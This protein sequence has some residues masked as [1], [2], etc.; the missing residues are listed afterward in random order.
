MCEV[1]K[2]NISLYKCP[3]CSVFSCSLACCKEHK[4]VQNCSGRRDK[5]AFV[6]IAQFREKHLRSDFHF[7]EDILQ[8]K[9]RAKRALQHAGG[10]AGGGASQSRK[11]LRDMEG[12]RAEEASNVA[13]LALTPADASSG[14]G[15]GPVSARRSTQAL[16]G[17]SAAV[18]RLVQAAKGRG[19]NLII[20]PPGMSKRVRNTTTFVTDD[21]TVTWRL[22]MVFV[23]SAAVFL[24]V[25]LLRAELE[26]VTQGQIA[27]LQSSSS[28]S[29][30][31]SG[32]GLVGTI[33]PKVSEN[34]TVSDILSYFLDPHGDVGGDVSSRAAQRYALRYLRLVPRSEL[35]M[36]I[37]SI[38]SPAQDPVFLDIA[39]DEEQ[40]TLQQALAGRTVIEYPT[41]IVGK[42]TDLKHCK[43]LVMEIE[44]AS[45]VPCL[46]ET[47]SEQLQDMPLSAA[48]A[49]SAHDR[50]QQGG[51]DG[52]S[53]DSDNSQDGKD[54]MAALLEMKG[55]NITALQNIIDEHN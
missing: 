24:P 28:L 27:Q 21:G 6:P 29:P 48:E 25:D 50:L 2:Q 51:S 11:R 15:I 19:T 46:V 53:S 8:T 52:T 55:K 45:P 42:K 37:Q 39:L 41:F 9:S 34:A 32:A 31:C 44:P 14:A 47:P 35:C 5:T 1:C 16:G 49:T 18:K 20:M 7:L 38:P 13:L 3:A 12:N 17:H 26:P 36:L 4:V 22:H 54:F 43:R 33:R 40:L 23:A 10:T 30:I